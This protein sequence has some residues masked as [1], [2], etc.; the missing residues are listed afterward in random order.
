MVGQSAVQHASHILTPSHMKAPE[1]QQPCT[2]HS[3]SAEWAGN[4]LTTTADQSATAIEEE[5]GQRPSSHGTTEPAQD[6]AAHTSNQIQRA[7]GQSAT[8]LQREVGQSPFQDGGRDDDAREGRQ[9]KT[10]E[11]A[12]QWTPDHDA[13]RRY[14]AD[15]SRMPHD[16]PAKGNSQATR[17]NLGDATARTSEQGTRLL[18]NTP[19]R[20][21]SPLVSSD[22]PG[23]DDTWGPSHVAPPN[24]SKWPF[25]TQHMDHSTAKIYDTVRSYG[26]HNHEGAKITLQTS[27]NLDRWDTET[28]GHNHDQIVLQ[29]VRYGFPIQYRGPPRYDAHPCDNHT[30]AVKYPDSIVDYIKKELSHGA[31]E[32]PFMEPPFTPWFNTS[33]LMTREKAETD[34]RRVIVDLSFPEGGINKYITPHEYNGNPATHNLPTVDHAVRSITDMCPGSIHLSVIDLSR[35]Y[36]QLPVSPLDWPLL[37]IVYENMTYFDRRIP[38]GSRMSS[39]SMQ[40]TADFLTRA[41]ATRKVVAH[42]YLDDIVL[43]SPNMEIAKRDYAMT[44]DLINALG[45][46]VADKKVQ[47][48]APRVRWLGINID[49]PKNQLSIPLPKVTQIKNCMAA[50]SG[51]KYL[52]KRHLQRIIGLANHLAKI[53]KAARVFICRILAALRSSEGDRITVCPQIRADLNWFKV[54]LKDADGRAIIPVNRVVGRIWADACPKGAGASDGA[55]CYMHSFPHNFTARH[56]ITQLEALNCLAA[57]RTLVGDQHKGGTIEVHCDNR[58]A[59]DALTSGRARD[60]VLA[61][62]AR[63]MW[64]HV[65][66]TQTDITFTHVPGEAMTLPDALSRA[67]TDPRADRLA[68]AFIRDMPLDEI[69][70]K[71]LVFE[72][73]EFM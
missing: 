16:M 52:T 22:A 68:R 50:A 15:D 41:L 44:M 27:L 11:P 29:G 40:M 37:G 36:R 31:L 20:P 62:C 9:Q 66:R 69:E 64:F 35:A 48:P 58:A 56:H 45:L 23:V 47:P 73:S 70:V 14:T 53:I 24:Y 54:Y 43:I 34:D 28:T 7:N 21:A 49:I 61:A 3:N 19:G 55:K 4:Q 18:T 12:I 42:M 60:V 5:V 2:R 32:G 26:K 57:V 71:Q 30:S 33:P 6:M 39:F 72:Y 8:V 13:H 65:A 1:G 38:F 67:T 59:M 17:K 25:P 51:K 46:Q 63:A 10:M